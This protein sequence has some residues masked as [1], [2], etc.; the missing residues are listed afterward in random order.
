MATN[1]GKPGYYDLLF[2]VIYYHTSTFAT[3]CLT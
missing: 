2:I 1:P 3:N